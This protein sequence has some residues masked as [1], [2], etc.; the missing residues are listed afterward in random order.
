[1]IAR[2]LRLAWR[3]LFALL[4]FTAGL[5]TV[6]LVY[7]LVDLPARDR[8]Q[9][10][11]MRRLLRVV[12]L[13]VSVSGP[14]LPAGHGVLVVSNHVSW[15]DAMALNELGP[16]AFVAK[17]EVRRWPVIGFL[18]ARSGTIYIERGRRR[19]VH[20]V[21]DAIAERLACS[22]HCGVFAEGTTTE[23]DRVLPFHSNLIK[24]ALIADAPVHPVC[25]VYRE[26]G[27]PSTTASFTGDATLLDSLRIVLPA[28]GLSVDIVALAPLHPRPDETRHA[29][30]ERARG[31][32]V[33][34]HAAIPSEAGER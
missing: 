15:L 14:R 18:A 13:S 25:L 7:P 16:I 17:S 10:R 30:A 8:I 22:R 33:A 27:R 4:H 12:G 3:V 26:H 5:L 9:S 2:G 23:G 19:A 31:A 11:W 28:T 1:M 34:A 6:L 24:S 29:L 21:I 20:G 32:I